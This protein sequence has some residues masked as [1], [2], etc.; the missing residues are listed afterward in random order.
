MEFL[1]ELFL[2]IG[3]VILAIVGYV[4]FQNNKIPNDNNYNK[5]NQDD[6][7]KEKSVD[8]N[9]QKTNNYRSTILERWYQSSNQ[10]SRNIF[11]MSILIIILAIFVI[12]GILFSVNLHPAESEINLKKELIRSFYSIIISGLGGYLLRLYNKESEKIKDS[13]DTL[14]AI[15]LCDSLDAEKKKQKIEELINVYIEKVKHKDT[16]GD[17][18]EVK[19]KKQEQ[20]NQD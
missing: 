7:G 2:L 3:V 5:V 4:L 20:K 18:Q 8:K 10:R 19:D 15:D 13:L 16:K 12:L 14:N 17:K 11:N 6:T 1:P 9:S